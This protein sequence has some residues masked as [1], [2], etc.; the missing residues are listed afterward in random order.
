MRP[1][2][3]RAPSPGP[4]ES[5]GE[6]GHVLNGTG[7]T[8]VSKTVRWARQSRET[9]PFG[10]ICPRSAFFRPLYAVTVPI[11]GHRVVLHLHLR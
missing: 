8:F 2:P 4:G 11:T 5:D 3:R 6:H 7:N 9:L 10:A 1:P